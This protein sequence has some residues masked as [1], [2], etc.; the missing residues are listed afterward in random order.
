LAQLTDRVLYTLANSVSYERAFS[1]LNQLYIKTRNSLT[2]ER[3][4]KLL[5]IQINSRTL[6]RD[7]LAGKILTDE[8]KDEEGDPVVDGEEDTTFTRPANINEALPGPKGLDEDLQGESMC[9]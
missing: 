5:Y 1:T 4:N 6:G 7:A 8:D 3:V 9:V 2:P